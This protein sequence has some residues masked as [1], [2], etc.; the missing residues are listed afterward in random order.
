MLPRVNPFCYINS[1]KMRFWNCYNELQLQRIK[2]SERKKEVVPNKIVKYL[3]MFTNNSIR[4]HTL[5]KMVTLADKFTH[6]AG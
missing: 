3:N 4:I 2:Y 6:K 5:A 1:Q